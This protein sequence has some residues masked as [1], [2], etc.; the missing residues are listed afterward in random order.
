MN[1][2]FV[3]DVKT[4]VVLLE[5]CE[6]E[7]E[8]EDDTINLAVLIGGGI[9]CLT[10]NTPRYFHVLQHLESD[11]RPFLDNGVIRSGDGR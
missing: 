3:P 1:E 2:R 7:R 9:W 11:T 4:S 5:S 10:C 6:H 8:I